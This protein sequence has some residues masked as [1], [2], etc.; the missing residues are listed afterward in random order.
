MQTAG[1]IVAEWKSVH[2][3]YAQVDRLLK[4]QRYKIELLEIFPVPSQGTLIAFLQSSSLALP[5]QDLLASVGLSDFVILEGAADHPLLESF[6]GL[7]PAPLQVGHSLGILQTSTAPLG[8]AI[9][10]ILRKA[11]GLECLLECKIL[12]NGS[13]VRLFV[14]ADSTKLQLA[15]K[16]VEPG[17][18]ESIY[19]KLIST[20]WESSVI[21]DPHSELRKLFAF[22]NI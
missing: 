11:L 3:G 22:E 15:F 21:H 1:I 5:G 6:Y 7:R 13:G 2:L 9:A 16:N 18:K 4:V 12:R 17:L 19:Q 20:T 8:V 10:E 14:G